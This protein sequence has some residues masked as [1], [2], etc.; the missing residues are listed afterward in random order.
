ML[1]IGT[2][3]SSHQ[4]VRFS[5]CDAVLISRHSMKPATSRGRVEAAQKGD[6]HGTPTADQVRRMYV[7][8]RN[9]A[10][11]NILDASILS[12]MEVPIIDGNILE[13]PKFSERFSALVRSRTQLDDTTKVFPL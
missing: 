10:M 8:T 12:K 5:F 11:F 6:D 13:Y 9:A 4:R 1:F 7:P 2:F 3:N